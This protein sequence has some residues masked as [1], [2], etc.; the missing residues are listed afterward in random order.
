MSWL[1]IV[2]ALVI[3]QRLGELW[4]AAR[5]T[6]RLK[7]Q[8]AV[9]YGAGHYPLFVVLH[10]AWIATI[11]GLTPWTTTPSASLL[12]IYLVLQGARIWVIATLGPFWT[13][14]IISLSGAPLVRDGPYR[15]IRHPNYWIASLEIAVLPLAFGQIGIALVFSLLNA[16]LIAYRVRIENAALAAR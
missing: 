8:G 7:A 6:R 2:L 12:L 16:L 10:A 4:L 15:F 13:T 3:A 5:N 1:P 14:R 11:A 9:E